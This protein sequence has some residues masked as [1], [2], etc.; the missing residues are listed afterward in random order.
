MHRNCNLLNRPSTY[1]HRSRNGWHCPGHR[2]IDISQ[3]GDR[4]VV[5]LVIVVDVRDRCVVN[6]RVRR[7]DARHVLRADAISRNVYVT[8]PQWEPADTTA[9]AEGQPYAEASASDPAHQ[10]GSVNR[11]G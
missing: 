3:I 5:R 8:W 6:G 10:S 2:L 4:V 7:I 11:P 1:H 9:T